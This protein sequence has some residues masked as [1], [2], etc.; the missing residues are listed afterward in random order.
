MKYPTFPVV[1]VTQYPQ[2]LNLSQHHV[3]ID[4]EPG[5]LF[6]YSEQI[7]LSVQK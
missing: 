2:D 4:E 1:F 7:Q 6:Y 3:T 5:E